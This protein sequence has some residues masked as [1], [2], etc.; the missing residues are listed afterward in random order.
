MFTRFGDFDRTLAMLDDFR[1]RMDRMWVDYDDAWGREDGADTASIYGAA[2]YPRVNLFDTGAA[3]VV[4]ADVPGM[5]EENLQITLNANTLTLQGERAPE[6][7]E[8]YAV[9][10]QERGALRFARTFS[11]PFKV[12]SEKTTASLKDGVLTLTLE[13]A[14]EARPRQITIK[15]S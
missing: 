12:D 15:A 5:T 14:A 1:R 13:K 8:N 10:R 2:A 9:H 11:L 3:L 6:K 4:Q 7:L